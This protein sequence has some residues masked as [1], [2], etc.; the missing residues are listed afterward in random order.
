MRMNTSIKY[1]TMVTA[2][3]ITAAI[4]TWTIIEPSIYLMAACLPG[5][6]HLFARMLPRLVIER[7]EARI[8]TARSKTLLESNNSTVSSNAKHSRNMPHGS[9]VRLFD[10]DSHGQVYAEAYK[11]ASKPSTQV[12]MEEQNPERIRVTTVITITQEERIATVLGI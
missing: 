10:M 5:M 4:F 11:D 3:S 1:T 6:H 8:A 12:D 7:T 2:P 9:F